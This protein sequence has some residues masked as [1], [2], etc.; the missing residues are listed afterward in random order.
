MN[1]NKTIEIHHA[2][3]VLYKVETKDLIL[4]IKIIGVQCTCFTL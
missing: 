1:I 3:K 2:N 4:Q